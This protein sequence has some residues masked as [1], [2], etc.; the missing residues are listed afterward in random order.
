MKKASIIDQ[1]CADKIDILF[2]M[3]GHTTGNSLPL[4][5]KKP[6]PIQ[7]SWAGYVGT[8]GISTMDYVMADRHHVPEGEDEF[9]TEN[10]IRMPNSYVSYTAPDY[11]PEVTE[12][13]F[14]KKGFITFGSFNNVI[15]TN[16]EVLKL[17]AEV[18]RAVPNSHLFI[19]YRGIDDPINRTRI[20]SVMQ[21]NGISPGRLRLEGSSP[22]AELL[23]SYGEIDI[24]LDTFPYSGGLT[25]CE[26]LWM[27][28]PVVTLYGN[29]FAGRHSSSHLRNIGLSEFVASDVA[30]YVDLAVQATSNINT[31]TTLRKNLRPMM[32]ASPLCNHQLF[33]LNFETAMTDAWRQFCLR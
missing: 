12:L 16:S 7:I 33:A 5:V 11:T 18:L 32:A 15:K 19:K 23:A 22:H 20:E 1:I 25:S 2:D 8:T 29:T 30:G 26:A 9:Y 31:M 24:A 6:A 4:F 13:P 14:K 28:V 3:S 27:G 21:D 17:W 10:I